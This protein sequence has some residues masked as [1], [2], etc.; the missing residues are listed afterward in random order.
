MS[1][2]AIFDDVRAERARQDEQWGEQNHPDGTGREG[3]KINAEYA[4]TA[5]EAAASRGAVTWRHIAT[6]EDM[7]ACAETDP[8]KLRAELIQAIA[9]K[10][11]WVEAID[12]RTE[13]GDQ[14]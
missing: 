3:D 14:P 13:R 7:E 2:D 5:C 6:E 1:I 12:R 4:R 11:A 10:V 9:V 8:A